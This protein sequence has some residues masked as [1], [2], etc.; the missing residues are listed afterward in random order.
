MPN[1]TQS[2]ISTRGR[3][4]QPQIRVL[5]VELGHRAV[6]QAAGDGQV[7][8]ERHVAA[9]HRQQRQ[10]GLGARHHLRPHAAAPDA[11]RR[12]PAATCAGT[13]RRRGSGSTRCAGPCAPHAA[14][15]PGQHVGDD[16]EV[17]AA[18]RGDH[19]VVGLEQRRQPDHGRPHLGEVGPRPADCPR[20][21]CR[22]RA[23]PRIRPRRP[24]A[25]AVTRRPRGRPSSTSCPRDRHPVR[26]PAMPT[27]THTSTG[28]AAGRRQRRRHQLDAA[29]R[30][31]PAHQCRSSGRRSVRR[32]ASATRPRRRAR[33]PAP[34]RA[35][36]TRGR[37]APG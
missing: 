30:V 20:G 32:P 24:A 4:P 13:A 6:G 14:G 19:D 17:R 35:R 2:P 26:P 18:A 16:V 31:H 12:P 21:R 8:V 36:R 7:L 10:V 23:R 11:V 9:A 3:R 27:S 22:D 28:R 5:V 34:G 29:H 33:W 25:A 1:S 37:R 15:P